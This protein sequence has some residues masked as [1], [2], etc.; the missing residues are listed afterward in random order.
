MNK[1]YIS[2][3]KCFICGHSKRFIVFNSMFFSF[4]STSSQLETYRSQP[5]YRFEEKKHDA[6]SLCFK[7]K[8]WNDVTREQHRMKNEKKSKSKFKRKQN[9]Q[10][11][12]TKWKWEE[13]NLSLMH[14]HTT[15]MRISF[16]C[17]FRW[18]HTTIGLFCVF[19]VV[20]HSFLL[21]H[22]IFILHPKNTTYIYLISFIKLFETCFLYPIPILNRKEFEEAKKSI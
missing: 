16:Y 4:F 21:L 19:V 17:I 2:L 12:N 22:F 14:I 10:T 6:F 18:T 13:K 3:M 11:V 9:V 20:G 1:I 15:D 7:F 5:V 8:F